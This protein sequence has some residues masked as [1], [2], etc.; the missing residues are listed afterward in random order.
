MA[1]HRSRTTVLAPS[2]STP[3]VPSPGRPG[4]IREVR[5]PPRGMEDGDPTFL[6]NMKEALVL[7]IG[8]EDG[9]PF[10]QQI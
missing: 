5:T 4:H 10:V 3:N 1:E 6:M 7:R 9:D 8:M 2:P